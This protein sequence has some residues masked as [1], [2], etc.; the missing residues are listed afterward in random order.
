MESSPDLEFDYYL[1]ERLHM[2]VAEM[3]ERISGEE[4][5]G[6]CIYYGRKGQR[7]ELEAGRRG[8]R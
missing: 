6:W 7:I 8:H 4:Y 5:L 1:A 2:T 3:R